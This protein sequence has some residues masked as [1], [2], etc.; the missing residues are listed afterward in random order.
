MN[1]VIPDVEKACIGVS[2]CLI[3][4]RVRYDGDHKRNSFVSDVLA[5]AFDVVPICPEVAVGMGV[6]RPAIRRA[7]GQSSVVAGSRYGGRVW[8]G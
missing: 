5:A 3:G 8:R 7:T 6:P 1:N 4:E 2:A